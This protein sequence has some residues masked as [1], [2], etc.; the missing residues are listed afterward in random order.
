MKY[1]PQSPEDQRD[2]LKSMGL[3]DV[4]ELFSEIPKNLRLSPDM[5]YPSAQSEQEIRKTFQKLSSLSKINP[6]SIAG[7]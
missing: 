1:I 2:L 4:E 3:Q 6:R 7:C 5:N